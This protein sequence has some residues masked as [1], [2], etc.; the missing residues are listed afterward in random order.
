LTIALKNTVQRK[1]QKKNLR[2][3]AKVFRL[4]TAHSRRKRKTN[5]QTD[6]QTEKWPE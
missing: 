5:R 6:R 4:L 2:D 3:S 1:F